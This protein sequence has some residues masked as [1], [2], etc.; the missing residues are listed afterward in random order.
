MRRRQTG[1][2]AHDPAWQTQTFG[3]EHAACGNGSMR[4]QRDNPRRYAP[5]KPHAS[6]N[7]GH[8]QATQLPACVRPQAS[9]RRSCHR[10]HQPQIEIPIAILPWP[11]GSFPGDFR[12]PAGARNSSRLRTVHF[13]I[14]IAT[15]QTLFEDPENP[16]AVQ[17]GLGRTDML[18]S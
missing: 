8:K 10:R 17:V 4:A 5:D 18:R 1:R 9:K 13:R 2:R 6:P 14:E 3:R 12:T 7:A 15:K 11:A 16:R